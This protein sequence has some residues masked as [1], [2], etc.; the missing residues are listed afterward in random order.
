M[1][2]LLQEFIKRGRIEPS[3]SEGAS[4]AFIMPKEEKGEWWLVVDY[5][6]LN[7]QTEH[8]LYSLPLIDTI[9]QRQA[10]KRIFTVFD[11]NKSYHQMLLHEKSRASTLMSTPLSPM[12]CNVVPMGAKNGTAAFQRMIEDLL[13]PVRDCAHPFVDGII[14]GSGTEDMSKDELIKAHDK[15]L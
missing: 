2:K 1:K 7:R 10:R 6:A 13:G 9:L 8:D 12:Q 4:P 3:D 15:D 5:Q 11:I 14:I